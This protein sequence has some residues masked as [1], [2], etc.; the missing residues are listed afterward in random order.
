MEMKENG[1]AAGKTNIEIGIGSLEARAANSDSNEAYQLVSD[2]AGYR[3]GLIAT[4]GRDGAWTFSVE[5]LIC[6][7]EGAAQLELHTLEKAVNMAKK[8][9][10]RGYTLTQ[11]DDGWITCEKQ[12]PRDEVANECEILMKFAA[13][14]KAPRCVSAKKE[15][16]RR[17]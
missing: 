6:V 2:G 12:L 13:T 9:K 11:Q 7:L 17:E 8:L 16:S 3:L 1:Q 5:L 14:S 4:E 10:S 15:T